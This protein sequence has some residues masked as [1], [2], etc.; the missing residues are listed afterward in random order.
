MGFRACN[1]CKQEI[2]N[3]A[4]T[5]PHCGADDPF[6]IRSTFGV[7]VGLLMA[8]SAVLFCVTWVLDKVCGNYWLWQHGVFQANRVLLPIAI[9]IGVFLGGSF[10]YTVYKGGFFKQFF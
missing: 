7:A 2:A 6:G 1:V 5:C 3:S 8:P 9:G 4:K 10:L